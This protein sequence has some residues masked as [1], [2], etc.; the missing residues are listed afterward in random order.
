MVLK[1]TIF[2]KSAS[3]VLTMF[4]FA[5]IGLTHVS[6]YASTIGLTDVS[7]TVADY[8]R[9][10]EMVLFEDRVLT[11]VSINANVII[12]PVTS[13][14]RTVFNRP[15][16]ASPVNPP[17]DTPAINKGL[18]NAP[19]VMPASVPYRTLPGSS[20]G[21]SLAIPVPAAAWLFGS[22]L[23]GLVGMARRKKTS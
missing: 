11:P 5:G 12:F 22:G 7:N 2:G 19:A 4:V 15:D 9:A 3:A 20:F 14:S 13:N 8:G 16:H 18:M 23:L 10:G 17:I 21:Q 1:I 6:A